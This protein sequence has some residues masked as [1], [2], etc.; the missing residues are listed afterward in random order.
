MKTYDHTLC[1]SS[2][3]WLAQ[4]THRSHY[5]NPNGGRCL[6]YERKTLKDFDWDRAWF[7]WDWMM[8]RPGWSI[9]LDYR[10]LCR[11]M[12]IAAGNKLSIHLAE[13]KRVTDEWHATR[14]EWCSESDD[15]FQA[16][17][18]GWKRPETIEEHR[19]ALM[20]GM[21]HVRA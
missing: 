3:K 16:I 13:R 17:K 15:P 6:L 5:L 10:G 9:D 11:A 2:E 8:S 14:D 21:G 4:L 18:M 12:E 19:A 7:H 1:L 20:N